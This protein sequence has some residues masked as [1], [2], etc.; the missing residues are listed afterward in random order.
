MA[1]FRFFCS[2]YLFRFGFDDA[3]ERLAT[4]RNEILA[5]NDSVAKNDGI[6]LRFDGLL[7]QLADI[8]S[9]AHAGHRSLKKD[10]NEFKTP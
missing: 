9:R 10:N 6:P 3:I 7:N 4:I 2:F 8:L 1:C 5:G